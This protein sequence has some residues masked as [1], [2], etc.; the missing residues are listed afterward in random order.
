MSRPRFSPISPERGSLQ[1][2]IFYDLVSQS[3]KT[4]I[5]AIELSLI[6]TMTVIITFWMI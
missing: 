4:G 2:S 1:Q 3:P 5:T 6:L